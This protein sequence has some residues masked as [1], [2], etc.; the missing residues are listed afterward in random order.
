MEKEF[1]VDFSGYVKIKAENEIE[2]EKKFWDFVNA[3]CDTSFSDLSDDVW[4]IDAIE[5]VYNG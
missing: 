2:A 1:W 4:D 5:E 3:N